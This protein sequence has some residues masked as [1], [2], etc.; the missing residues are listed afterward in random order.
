ME[1]N[2]EV[3]EKFLKYGAPSK[4]TKMTYRSHLNKYFEVLKIKDPDSYFDNGRDYKYDVK[5]FALAIR[6]E[7]PN[8]QKT[9]LTC[10]KKFLSEYDIE[11]PNKFWNRIKIENHLR[12]N[13][14]VVEEK[15]PNNSQLKL[16]LQFGGTK[17]RALFLMNATSGTRIDENLNL[18]FDD[19]DME[20]RLIRIREETTKSRVKRISFFTQE[21]KDAL[22]AW[23]E[24]RPKYLRNSFVKSKYVR[25]LFEKRGYKFKRVLIDKNINAWRWDVYKDG[26]KITD[27]EFIKAEN[28][29]FPFGYHTALETWNRMLEEAGSPFNERDEN[30]KL[31]HPRYKYHIHTLRKFWFRAFENTEANRNHINSIGAHESELNGTYAKFTPE[32][33]KETYDQYSNSLSIFSDMDKF[34][35]LYKPKIAEQD[36]AISS[37][38]RKNKEYKELIQQLKIQNE[39]LERVSDHQFDRIRM[40]ECRIDDMSYQRALDQDQEKEEKEYL[41]KFPTA[42]ERK[43]DWDRLYNLMKTGSKDMTAEEKTRCQFLNNRIYWRLRNKEGTGKHWIDELIA[44]P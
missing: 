17:E 5:D 14:T 33:L 11:F 6:T 21:A 15:I 19:V 43:R 39:K 28:R 4:T 29:I 16:I 32:T 26:K 3:I 9:R 34:D 8:T 12:G 35:E 7:P 20:N 38:T 24:L 13:H 44:S 1:K 2:S 25:E 42:K 10:I 41:K 27:E 18:T 40:L 36:T 30:P 37:L 31:K 23:L 22:E